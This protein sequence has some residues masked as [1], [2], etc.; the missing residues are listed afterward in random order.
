MKLGLNLWTVYGWD[1][2]TLV[3]DDVLAAT[4]TMGYTGV[5]L[6][7]DEGANSRG[8]LLANRERLV[9]ALLELTLDVPSVATTLFWRYNLAS[10][11]E[12]LRENGMQVIADGCQ[13]AQAYGAGVFL[14]VAGQQEPGVRYARSYMT[15]VE[16]IRTAAEQVADTGVVVGVENVRTSLLCSPGEYAQFIADVDHPLVQAYLDFG[17][18]VSVGPSYPENWVEAVAGRTAMMH[19]KDYDRATGHYVCCG[20]G[21]LP[22][23]DTFGAIRE[24]GYDGYVIV[25]TPPA[26]GGGLESGLHA[27]ETSLRW[28]SRFV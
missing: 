13:V 5:E 27:A 21:D 8:S 10:Q 4:A 26:G 11:N 9:D 25:E 16:T 20:L 15:A 23:G 19:A 14:V 3:S 2:D 28:L 24:S 22:W 6:V 18:G 17:N 12:D 1:L 7:L